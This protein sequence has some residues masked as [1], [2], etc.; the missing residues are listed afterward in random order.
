MQHNQSDGHSLETWPVCS[1]LKQTTASQSLARCSVEPHFWQVG[2]DDKTNLEPSEPHKPRHR[3]DQFHL[4]MANA[5][6][7]FL[8]FLA[9]TPTTRTDG[10][11]GC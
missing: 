7:D 3:L 2:W 6:E 5:I 9:F 8:I 4:I 10:T 11:I 1:Q